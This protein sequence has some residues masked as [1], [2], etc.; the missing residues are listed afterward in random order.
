MYIFFTPETDLKHHG[1]VSIYKNLLNPTILD[2]H[3]TFIEYLEKTN[4]KEIN[5]ETIES[6]ISISQISKK[7]K[8]ALTSCLK[9]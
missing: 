8:S 3:Y 5:D 9:L 4:P 7:N 1:E 6:I 2:N